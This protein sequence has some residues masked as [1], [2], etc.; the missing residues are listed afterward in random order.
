MS[1]A[2]PET[3]EDGRK[4]EDRLER[5]GKVGEMMLATLFQLGQAMLK[6]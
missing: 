2:S 6:T 1:K 5:K 4:V 3:S